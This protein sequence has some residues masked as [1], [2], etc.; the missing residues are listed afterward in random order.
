MRNLHIFLPNCLN[1]QRKQN[2]QQPKWTSLFCWLEKIFKCLFVLILFDSKMP[3]LC[4]QERYLVLNLNLG[5]EFYFG[6][7]WNGKFS[8]PHENLRN[9]SKFIKTLDWFHDNIITAPD[10]IWYMCLGQCFSNRVSRHICVSQVSPIVS[11]N[12]SKT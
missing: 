12:D 10:C 5:E 8:R 3:I 4:S 7:S 6:M 11:P 9:V 1:Y 2:N